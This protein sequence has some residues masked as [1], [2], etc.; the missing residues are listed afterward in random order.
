VAALP[1][2]V[3]EVRPAVRTA[4][5]ALPPDSLVLVACSGGADSL[6]L[7]AQ[8]AFLAPR[9]SLRA[10]LVTVDQRPPAG[11]GRPRGRRRRSGRLTSTPL[12]LYG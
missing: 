7:A 8:T 4:L 1:P 10:G 11:L 5:A 9:M 2:G 3:A 6:A 12:M